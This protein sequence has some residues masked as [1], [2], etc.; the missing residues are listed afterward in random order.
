VVPQTYDQALIILA[1][2]GPWKIRKLDSAIRHAYSDRCPLAE[3]AKAKSE[4]ISTRDAQCDLRWP[5][6]IIR[7]VE[8]A[9]DI[10]FNPGR[11]AMLKALKPRRPHQ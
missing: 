8:H 2:I 11:Q 1:K 10:T 3:L 6:D 4:V 7:Q 5:F 9:A